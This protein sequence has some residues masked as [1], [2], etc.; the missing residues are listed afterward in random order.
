M[1]ILRVHL[2]QLILL[3][4]DLLEIADLLLY[5]AGPL[6]VL[7]FVFQV[8]IQADFSGDLLNRALH[9]VK[10]A[11]RLVLCAGVS[12]YSSCRNLV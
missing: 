1:F 12:W 9:F 10:R 8:G 2:S 4:H 5:F 3:P 6:F 11:L 7:T